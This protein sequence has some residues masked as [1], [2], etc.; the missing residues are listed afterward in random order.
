[1]NRKSSR[2]FKFTKNRIGDFI[3]YCDQCGCMCWAS[4]TV[5]LDTYSGKGNIRVC[6]DDYDGIDYGLVPYKIPAEK[7]VPFARD[8]VYVSNPQAIPETFKPFN[9]ALFDPMST[10]PSQASS[11]YLSWDKLNL[12]TWNMWN[13]PWGANVDYDPE[14]G[15]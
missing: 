10:S 12:Q 11:I 5:P 4:E 6:F 1:M 14:E 8:T 15:N 3:T 13:I 9:A 2:N 7:P